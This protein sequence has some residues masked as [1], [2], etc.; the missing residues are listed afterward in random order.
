MVFRGMPPEPSG[1]PSR[2]DRPKRGRSAPEIDKDHSDGRRRAPTGG[3]RALVSQVWKAVQ[4]EAGTPGPALLWA[5][6]QRHAPKIFGA[7]LLDVRF[8]FSALPA[9]SAYVRA[10]LRRET[11]L[12][13]EAEE[14][15]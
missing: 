11:H 8:A 15:P 2:R 4:A 13:E 12:E 14:P 6:L 1:K 3:D 10:C 7:P 5:R 9:S